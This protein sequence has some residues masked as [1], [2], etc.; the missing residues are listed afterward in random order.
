MTLLEPE[1]VV[2]LPD[3]RDQ[4]L[5][6][7]EWAG[8]RG[9]NGAGKSTAFG[10]WLWLCRMEPYPESNFVAV[11]ASYRQLREG[12]FSTLQELFWKHGLV[13][14]VDFL[15]RGG[16]N[17][18]PSLRLYNG[19]K[20]HAWTAEMA[21]RVKGANVQTI[22]IEE[23]QTWGPRAEDAFGAVGSRLRVNS[24][25]ATLY[26]DLKPQARLSFNPTDVV[27]GHWLHE[28]VEDRWPERGYRCWRMSTR[29]NEL[30]LKVDPGYIERL[31]TI[32]APSKWAVE[33]DGEYPTRGG[34]AYREYDAAVH[35]TVPD[36]LPIPNPG[37]D[38]RLLDPQLPLFWSFDFN[39]ALMCS[40]LIQPR[41]QPMLSRIVVDPPNSPPRE[42]REPSV[43]GWQEYLF[44]VPDEIAIADAGVMAIVPEFKQRGYIEHVKAYTA[45]TGKPGLYIYG[46]ST[47]NSRSQL[48]AS[49]T[50]WGWILADLFAA[51]LRLDTPRQRGHIKLRIIDN[52]SEG[53][54]VNMVNAQLNSGAGYGVVVDEDRCPELLA[55]FR[56]MMLDPIKSKLIKPKARDSGKALNRSHMSDAFGYCIYVE[57]MLRFN[58]GAKLNWT[59]MR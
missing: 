58:P 35:L 22:V 37:G 15:Y 52:P 49:K 4:L 25:S 7:D 33:I 29:D 43:P 26:P 46:D 36:G 48:D 6:T 17:S 50:D 47:G 59:L 9:G 12:I 41:H 19:A 11:G 27:P 20:L 38:R 16:S 3:Q 21:L 40:V 13:E 31:Q 1:R 8:S 56:E 54:R 23:P 34:S 42:K 24:H 28:Q 30:L 2:L 57:R 10:Y 39:V 55:D 5:C 45:R 51:G 32:Y 18:A 44:Y 14:G 53:D